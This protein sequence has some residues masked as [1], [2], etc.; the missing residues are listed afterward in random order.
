MDL[1]KVELR[2]GNALGDILMMT[3]AVRDFKNHY[4]D[5]YLVRVNTTCMH[6]WDNNPNLSDYEGDPD[7]I[8]NLGPGKA[9]NGSNTS[10]LH[11]ANGFRLSLE[12][13]INLP[14]NQGHIKPDLHLTDQEKKQRWIDG[15][16]WI[17][18]AGGKGDFTTKWWPYQRWQK[19]VDALPE[20][21][22]VQVGESKHKTHR[23]LEGDNVINLIG[24]TEDPDTGIRDLMSL[25]YHCDGSVG[26]VSMQMHMAAA[27]D[28]ACVVIAGAREPRSYENYNDHV[29]LTNQGT[30][31]CKN[32]CEN[33][34]EFTLKIDNKKKEKYCSIADGPVPHDL[35]YSKQLCKDYKP[36]NPTKRYIYACWKK[37]I[38]SCCNHHY[39]P[40]YPGGEK[41][42][43]CIALIQ[44]EDVIRGIRSYYDN[45]ALTPIEEPTKLK[46]WMIVSSPKEFAETKEDPYPVPI[47][48]P[49][50]KMLCNAHNYIGGEKSATWIMRGMQ[51]RGYHVQCVPTKRVCDSFKMN[52]PGVEFTKRL[53]DPCDILMIYANDAIWDFT[54]PKYT[55]VMDKIKAEKKVMMLNFKIGGAAKAEWAKTWDLYGFLCSE[56][57]D[58]Y[59]EAVPGVNTF[60]LP[61]AV[62]IDEYLEQDAIVYNRTLHIVRHSSQG[63]NKYSQDEN[64]LIEAIRAESPTTVFSYMPGPSF[65]GEIP[66]VHNYRFAE[67][68]VIE[69][70]KRGTCFWYRL[71]EG[72]SDQGPRTIVEAMALGLPCIADNRWGAKDRITN[73]TGWL[74]EEFDD[75]VGIVLGLDAKTLQLKG[76]AAKNRAREQ[77]HPDNW[78][79]TIING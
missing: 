16:Y 25:Y 54:K 68:P 48:K 22:F 38:N 26:L 17:L 12:Q 37:G 72:Y 55:D 29:Y 30:L 5:K 34:K 2:N 24:K 58:H 61:P 21:T 45:G 23:P 15:R 40:Y 69:F 6:V 50:F 57:R 8:C 78:L 9:T 1:I 66:K 65:L 32:L 11:Y 70:L 27:F 77:F 35:Y 14:I 36:E 49:I 51:K 19:V 28:K 46:E 44:P 73:E 71:P 76:E 7:I 13:N 18:V 43:K 39:D 62:D 3:C 56:L 79:E 64:E 33:C 31:R 75:Y 52:S 10:G 67:L 47:D 63:D 4:R 42:A 60:V 20:I 53:T 59:L 74:C 41:F